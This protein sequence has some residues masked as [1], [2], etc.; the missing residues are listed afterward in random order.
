MKNLPNQ[1]VRVFGQDISVEFRYSGC[2]C[3]TSRRTVYNIT[4]LD[5]ETVA[6]LQDDIWLY[7]S[8]E[9]EYRCKKRSFPYDLKTAITFTGMVRR[10]MCGEWRWYPVWGQ[11]WYDHEIE[12]ETLPR[13]DISILKRVDLFPRR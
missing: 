8:K 12:W 3:E 4:K 6:R 5:G 9:L 13:T 11:Q 2:G 10:K 7:R 1:K